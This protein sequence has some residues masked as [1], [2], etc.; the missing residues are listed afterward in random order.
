M[1]SRDGSRKAKHKIKA[2][3]SLHRTRDKS[4]LSRQGRRKVLK[5]KNAPVSFDEFRNEDK[6]DKRIGANED[7]V[8]ILEDQQVNFD[9]NEIV[10][11]E[12]R[13]DDSFNFNAAE[14]SLSLANEGSDRGD[15]FVQDNP[16]EIVEQ[17]SFDKLENYKDR[18]P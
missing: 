11:D 5:A 4:N 7:E 2:L 10:I 17:N 15:G 16:V 18:L 8:Q 6:F 1:G 13:M 14:R 12:S 9:P 3:A